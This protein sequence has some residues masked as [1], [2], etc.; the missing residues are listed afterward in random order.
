MP[1]YAHVKNRGGGCKEC[2]RVRTA[3]AKRI[4]PEAAAKLMRSEGYEPLEPFLEGKTPWRCIHIKCGS[5]VSPRYTNIAGGQGGCYSC[6][7]IE[8]AKKRR[9][10]SNLCMDEI[11]NLGFRPIEEFKGVKQRWKCSCVICEQEFTTSLENA[12]KGANP[13][14]TPCNRARMGKKR[15]VPI[16]IA[17]RDMNLVGLDPIGEFPGFHEFWNAK[18]RNCL[19]QTQILFAS[20]RIRIAKDPLNPVQGCETCVFASLGKSR[21]LQQAD[22]EKRLGDLGMKVTGIYLGVFEPIAAICLTCGIESDVFPGHAFTKGHACSNCALKKRNDLFRKPQDEAIS[23]MLQRGYKPLD[24]YVTINAKWRSIHLECGNEASPSLSHVMRGQGGCSNCAKYGFDSTAPAIFYVLSNKKF[25]AIKVGITGATSTRLDSLNKR[26]GW[27]VEKE[28]RFSFGHEAR[29]VEK[30]V[31]AWWR[32]DLNAP[33]ALSPIDSGSL[34]GWTETASLELVSVKSTL[35][36]IST[37][38]NIKI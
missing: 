17:V 32:A 5:A 22:V 21:L 35:D 11:I 34:G 24:P 27:R 6:G 26:H 19:K 10:D 9:L 31:L 8:A 36:F 33:I 29:L 3:N 2:G 14:C 1:T 16:E 12:R 30:V 28:F 4:N 25:N 15:R 37:I 7:K 18:C 23:E 13:L 20:I 38:E